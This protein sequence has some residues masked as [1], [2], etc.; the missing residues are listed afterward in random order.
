MTLYKVTK[1]SSFYKKFGIFYRAK[2]LTPTILAVLTHENRRFREEETLRVHI[3]SERLSLKAMHVSLGNH[4]AVGF[5][6]LA[7]ILIFLPLFR[8]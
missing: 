8:W 2:M 7:P 4:L 6:H 5:F 3:D 1:F